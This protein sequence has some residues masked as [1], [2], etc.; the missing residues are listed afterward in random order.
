MIKWIRLER[1]VNGK[2][3]VTILKDDVCLHVDLLWQLIDRCIHKGILIDP[4][5]LINSLTCKGIGSTV[6]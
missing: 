5:Q 2:K 6:L 1:E 4:D 3:H